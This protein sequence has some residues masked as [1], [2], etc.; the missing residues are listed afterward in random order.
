MDVYLAGEHT[1]K[2]GSKADW[3]GLKILESFY[4]ARKN[5][6]FSRLVRQDYKN[7]LLDSGAF[8]FMV[9]KK[10]GNSDW[11]RY[12]EELAE[13]VNQHKIEHFFELD[14]ESIIGI[15][16]VERLRA[17]LE[18]LT[19]KQSIPVWHKE[20][21]KDYYLGMIKDYPY[22]AIG[23]LV[24]G[25]KNSHEDAFP[26]FIQQAHI[27]GTK[28]HGLGYT[29]LEGLKKFH[30]DS[31][32]STAWLYGNMSGVVYRFNPAKGTI[33]KIKA[34]VGKR[35]RSQA[36][37]LNNFNEWVKFQKYADKNL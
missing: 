23:G 29:S 37:A 25:D 30:F 2:N 35:L 28:L 18:R 17:K 22:V 5:K 21:G 24:T 27:N 3:T 14:I 19:G 34:P 10:R 36:V 7:L 20:R 11:D 15:K 31:V 13:F 33:D 1:F 8:S 12:V 32:D 26:W 6:E 4:Y 16:E 9:D